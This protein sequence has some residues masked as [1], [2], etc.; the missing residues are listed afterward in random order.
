M[1]TWGTRGAS[2]RTVAFEDDNEAYFFVAAGECAIGDLG[3]RFLW[4][5]VTRI[6]RLPDGGRP[7]P[8]DVDTW[9]ERV[10]WART[11]TKVRRDPDARRLWHRVYGRLSEGRSGMLGAMTAR[12]EAQV[13]RLACLYA[14]TDGQSVVGL[15]HLR[16]ALEVWRYAFE[17]VRYIFGRTLGH[18]LADELLEA[19]QAAPGGLTRK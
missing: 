2:T 16:A 8:V 7:V 4:V 3:N 13:M 14:L 12:A 18:P 15:S 17:S 1:T 10:L 11:V 9:R 5:C 6:R 19:I